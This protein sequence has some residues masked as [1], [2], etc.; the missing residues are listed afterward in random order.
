MKIV[1]K[2]GFRYPIA[3]ERTYAKLLVAYVNRI[4]TSIKAY[5]PD[6][7]RLIEQYQVK[8]DADDD[9]TT[10][11][12]RIEVLIDQLKRGIE[13]PEGMNPVIRKQFK[14]LDAHVKKELDVIIKSVFDYPLQPLPHGR[15]RTDALSDDLQ[16]LEDIWVQ[17]NLDLIK[18][19]DDV[20]MDKIR[21]KLRE[22]IINNVDTA[23]L[24]ND[25]IADINDIADIDTKRAVLIGCDQVG[26]LN[27]RLTQYRQ[28]HAGIDEY[29]WSTSHDRRVRP[30]H[31]EYD[32]NTYAWDSAPIGGHPGQAIRCRCV[33]IPVIDL[34][35]IGGKPK[36]NSFVPL[37]DNGIMEEIIR[38]DYD[39]IKNYQ[40]KLN[41]I[42]VRKWYVYHDESIPNLVDNTLPIEEAA[43]IACELRNNYRTQARNLMADQELRKELDEKYPNLTFEKLVRRKMKTKGMTREEAVQDI[44]KTAT[45]TNK[46]VNHNLGLE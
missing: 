33:A 40:G 3:L 14:L 6:M 5:V 11:N 17:Q 27:G 22:Y 12:I 37:L 45:K 7:V 21:D 1:P 32:G 31:R 30:Q 19:I 9:N 16:A 4:V 2:R 10:V 20:T 41:D 24:T 28:Q 35:K 25:L 38:T 13:Q 15:K 18:S 44:Y 43:A 46:V 23:S 29:K 42:T 34:D 8:F 39:K 26:K 36:K